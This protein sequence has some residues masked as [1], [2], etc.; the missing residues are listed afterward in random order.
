LKLENS[1]EVPVQPEKAWDLLMDVPRIVPCMPG[2]ELTEVVDDSHWKA[3]MTVKL[4]PIGLVFG[5]DV[6]RE[7]VDEGGRRVKLSADARELRG[8]GN[9]RATIESTLAQADG[10]TRVNIVTDLALTGSV[11]QY[12]RGLIQDISA[13]MI[14]R[15]AECLR[16]QLVAAPEEVREAVAAQARPV[17]GL[18][19]AFGA[20]GRAIKRLFARRKQ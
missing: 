19:L 17:A 14:T 7:E 4:G 3:E 5:T 15:F 9:C 10:G 8:R 20:F 11:A 6:V 16:T 13:Q 1:F 12:G 2:A 18:R